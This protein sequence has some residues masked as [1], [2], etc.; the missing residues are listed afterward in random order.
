MDLESSDGREVLLSQVET[1]DGVISDPRAYVF[2][3]L[4]L[5]FDDLRAFN[6]A[7]GR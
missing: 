7:P 3:R 2:I 1:P 5:S 6:P 4:G